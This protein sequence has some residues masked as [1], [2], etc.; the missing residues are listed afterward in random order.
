MRFSVSPASPSEKP[1]AESAATRLFRLLKQPPYLLTGTLALLAL[2]LRLRRLGY[3][4]FGHDQ[5]RTINIALQWL[6]G[7]PP[8]L[9]A[10]WSSLGLHNPP[11][12]EYLYALPL[13]FKEDI[14]GLNW[15]LALLHLLGIL[16]AGLAI[17]RVFGWRVGWWASLLFVVNP[18]AG[19]Y[20]R[21]VWQASF[22]PAFAAIFF[23]CVLVYFTVDNRPRYLILGALAFAATV[24]M[25]W[26]ALAL[27]PP[28]LLIGLC[29]FRRIHW[30]HFLVGA[31]LFILSFTPFIL[32]QIN[33]RFADL[34]A[35]RAGLGGRL[36]VNWTA[37]ELALDLFRSRT[38]YSTLGTAEPLWRAWDWGWLPADRIV[39]IWLSVGLI[40]AAWLALTLPKRF[41]PQAAGALILALWFCLPIP[42]FIPHTRLLNNHYFLYLYPVP[43][44]LMALA[45][46]R[47]ANWL[48][49]WAERRTDRRW[50]R[51][52]ITTIAFLP[53]ALVAFQQGRINVG[54]QN[55]LAAGASGLQR[56]VDTQRAIDAARQLMDARPDCQ[57]VVINEDVVW[58]TSRFG[59][60]REM[61]GP[62]QVRFAAA[63]AAYLLPSPCAVYFHITTNSPTRAWLGAAA[64]PL[65][66]YTI[67][68]PEETWQFYDLPPEARAAAAAH[69]PGGEPLGAWDNDLSLTNTEVGGELLGD[70][71][72][73]TYTWTIGNNLP[74][75][76]K[77][78]PTS[79]RFGNYLLMQDISLV[80]QSDE[81]GLDSREWQAG[82]VFQTVFTLPVPPD[83][84]PGEYTL[85]TA[86]Y[87]LPD[88]TRILL[89]D[90]TG[91][92]LFLKRLHKPA[93]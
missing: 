55:L 79:L 49:A 61:V 67:R 28:L 20:A 51:A 48:G 71:L 45:S 74:A 69:L 50:M 73:L 19:Y 83:L 4:E 58:E 12:V 17:T 43:L 15:L 81:V 53:P 85:A 42:V 27:L 31:T 33:T 5:S 10:D 6:H 46:E 64:R 75:D 87:S 41:D 60:L 24:Q 68:T 59:L 37:L 11:L 78:R 22:T 54:G 30:K 26:T 23:A 90:G 52:V 86:I 3:T 91:D 13:F 92:L 72:T 7:G 1:R 34:Q 44:V 8:P 89:A 38:I 77:L 21:Y 63:G 93:P 65:P 18:W 2:W 14:L 57:L 56:A 76:L 25:H 39:I 29:F 36:D 16:A 82:D 80:S 32:Y 40:V 88:V 84:A 66:N 47:L 35:M 62:R 70:M 9:A